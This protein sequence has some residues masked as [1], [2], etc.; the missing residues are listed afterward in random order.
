MSGQRVDCIMQQQRLECPPLLYLEATYLQRSRDTP[1]I[2]TIF[3]ET[4]LDAAGL[5][6]ATIV[7]WRWTESVQTR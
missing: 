3:M 2:V 6:H 4:T 1:S 5:T 7:D